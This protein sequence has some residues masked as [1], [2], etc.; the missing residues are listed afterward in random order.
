VPFSHAHHVGGSVWTAGTATPRW[1]PQASR[2][3]PP[4]RLA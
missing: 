3:Y 4:P 1:K 2:T